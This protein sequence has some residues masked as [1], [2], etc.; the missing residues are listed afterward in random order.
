MDIR[1]LRWIYGGCNITE[2]RQWTQETPPSFQSSDDVEDSNPQNPPEYLYIC[3]I[4][5]KMALL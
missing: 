3:G 2:Y 4:L 1:T 5:L